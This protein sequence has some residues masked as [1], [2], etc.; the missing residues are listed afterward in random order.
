MV[1]QDYRVNMTIRHGDGNNHKD[2]DGLSRQELRNHINN[3]AY[4][5]DLKERDVL[6]A[7]ECFTEHQESALHKSLNINKSITNFSVIK[8]LFLI[9]EIDSP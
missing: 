4:D 7:L 1:T 3:T 9:T 2:T 5:E 6:S 8:V